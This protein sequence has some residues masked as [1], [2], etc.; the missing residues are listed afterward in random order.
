[1][2]KRKFKLSKLLYTLIIIAFLI[3][4]FGLPI[5]FYT[6][7]VAKYELSHYLKENINSVNYYFKGAK[8]ITNYKGKEIQYSFNDD[9]IYEEEFSKNYDKKANVKYAEYL[10]TAKNIEYPEYISVYTSVSTYD[11]SILRQKLYFLGISEERSFDNELEIKN[12]VV[13]LLLDLINYLGDDFNIY[14]TQVI[15]ECDDGKYELEIYD[16]RIPIKKMSIEDLTRKV[17]KKRF[18]K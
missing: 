14:S 8:Y 16:R 9:K 10:K 18:E 11:Y 17:T 6:A 3:R 12:R 1:M 7:F 4:F 13:E 2:K 15:Y 5:P